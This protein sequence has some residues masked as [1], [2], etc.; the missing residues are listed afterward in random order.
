[1]RKRWPT[2]P[3]CSSTAVLKSGRPVVGR[4]GL[5]Q[6]DEHRWLARQI[7][8]ESGRGFPALRDEGAA[9][10]QI[11]R[12]VADERELWRHGQVGAPAACFAR[13]V[14][15]QPGIAREVA[16]ERVD[17]QQRDFHGVYGRSHFSLT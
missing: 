17:L 13:R 14:R 7:A 10:Q 3:S 6:S 16:D 9:Q 15:N 4:I 5:G 1:M 12:Q 8:R 11:A 2:R